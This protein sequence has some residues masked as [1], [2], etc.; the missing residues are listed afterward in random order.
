MQRLICFGAFGTLHARDRLPKK[1]NSVFL[2]I[3]WAA[4]L[5]REFPE[6]PTDPTL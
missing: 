4:M 6:T 1:D 2:F 5:L 3:L